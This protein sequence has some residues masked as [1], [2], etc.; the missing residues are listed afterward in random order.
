MTTIYRSGGR[1]LDPR[2]TMDRCGC[3]TPPPHHPRIPTLVAPFQRPGWVYE[4][5]VDG[6]RILA[7]RNGD[8]V[9]L[10][11]RTGQDHTKRFPD[12]AR[13]IA[14]LPARALILDG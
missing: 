10:I 9:R 3:P 11:S 6:W 8:T 1:N 12:V 14:Q 5:K 4:E 13:T 7:Y 2:A